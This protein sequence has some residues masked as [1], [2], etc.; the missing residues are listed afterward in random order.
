MAQKM[1]AAVVHRFREP[2]RLEEVP[3]PQPGEG[4]ILIKVE[5]S[6]VCHTTLHA[7]SGDWPVK[8]VPHFIPGHEGAG[9]VVAAGP[10]ARGVKEGDH[11]GVPWLY[12]AC[13]QCAYCIGGWETLCEAQQDCG[14]SVNGAFAMRKV[15]GGV[16]RIDTPDVIG[17]SRVDT[18]LFSHSVMLWKVPMKSLDNQR[19]G[20]RVS[21]RHE[22]AFPFVADPGV[23]PLEGAR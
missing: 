17:M 7:A 4:E 23:T 19:F 15:C 18:A 3:V 1:K 22:V 11:A 21:V 9:V 6:G 12:S 10:H 20:A 14:C 5:A 2:L 16:E 8:S 13:G